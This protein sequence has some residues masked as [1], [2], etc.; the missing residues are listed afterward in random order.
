[1]SESVTAK[2]A[3]KPLEKTATNKITTSSPTNHVGESIKNRHCD[4]TKADAEISRF[5]ITS[6]PALEWLC[7]GTR[8]PG[9]L[10]L[11]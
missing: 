2:P 11:S 5:I 9:N 4:Q 8:I 3:L 7:R 10:L 6:L 1:M